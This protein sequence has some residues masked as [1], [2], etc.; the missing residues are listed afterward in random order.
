MVALLPGLSG[1]S[2]DNSVE[3]VVKK[4]FCLAKISL[5]FGAYFKSRLDNCLSL[6]PFFVRADAFANK[7]A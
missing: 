7:L 1:Q 3:W 5:C 4:G 2:K 6:R